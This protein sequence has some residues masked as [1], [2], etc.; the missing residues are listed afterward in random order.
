MF[1]VSLSILCALPTLVSAKEIKVDYKDI[2]YTVKQDT[3][4]FFYQDK[5]L[6]KEYPLKACNKKQFEIFWAQYRIN[7]NDLTSL[8]KV[9]NK[10][11]LILKDDNKTSKV[12]PDG[13]FGTFLTQIPNQILA[14]E[15]NEKME[16]KK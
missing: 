6:K 5:T 10:E 4:K 12:D 11:P 8:N 7:K 14:F 9:H 2:S 1:W 16:C 3:K 15:I 13:K